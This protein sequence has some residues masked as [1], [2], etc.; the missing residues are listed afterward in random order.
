MITLN[1][2][3]QPTTEIAINR[4]IVLFDDKMTFIDFTKIKD[5]IMHD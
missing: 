1:L 3:H 4:T 5:A 2:E